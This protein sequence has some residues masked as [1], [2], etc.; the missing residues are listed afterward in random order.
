MNNDTNKNTNKDDDPI[1]WSDVYKIE[2]GMEVDLTP[3]ADMVDKN[4][5][6]STTNVSLSQDA[7][8][9]WAEVYKI[10]EDIPKPTAIEYEG[11]EILPP[12]KENKAILYFTDDVDL[13]SKTVDMSLR[14]IQ[15]LPDPINY[16]QE[17]I[18]QLR[19]NSTDTKTKDLKPR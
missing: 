12:V 19:N 3:S 18:D 11:N 14:E 8:H 6:K 15:E 7:I 5:R 1:D 9:Q 10:E 16:L 4:T 13:E 17:R 2:S